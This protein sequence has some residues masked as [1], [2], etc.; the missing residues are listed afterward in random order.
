MSDYEE[1]GT[2]G[3]TD[4]TRWRVSK[5]GVWFYVFDEYKSDRDGSW[6]G[7]KSK[8]KHPYMLRV[9]QDTRSAV[10]D[11]MEMLRDHDGA[12]PF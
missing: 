12:A 10:G 4:R 8:Q 9:H 3:L 6:W 5:G 2:V 7:N 11:L 1:I